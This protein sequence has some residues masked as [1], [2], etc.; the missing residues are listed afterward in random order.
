MSVLA[1]SIDF[2]LVTLG[3][4][5]VCS[6][7]NTK[8]GSFKLLRPGLQTIRDFSVAVILLPLLIVLRTSLARTGKVFGGEK[9]EH[10]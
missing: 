6:E 1:P 8:Q 3:G 10:R 5:D 7:G 4:S 2:L 9:V